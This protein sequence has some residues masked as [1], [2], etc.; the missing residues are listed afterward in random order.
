MVRMKVNGEAVSVDASP[1]TPLLWVIREKL[2]LT[3]T[4]FGCGIAQCGACTVHLNGNPVRS[5]ALPLSAAE[6]KDIT[7]VEG[8]M[9]TPTGQALQAGW[10][11]AQ[12]PQCGYCQSGQLMTAAKVISVVKKD[13]SRTEILE[14]MSG[15]ICRCGT[16]NQI[17]SAVSH[18]QKTLKGGKA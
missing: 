16:Y 13:L 15:N 5:C 12:A 9:K 2:N 14:A 4:K 8:L 18:A 10:V 17:A 11:K 7:T 6:G 1:E 3:G